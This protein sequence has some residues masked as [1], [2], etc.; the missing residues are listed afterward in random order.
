MLRGGGRLT[1]DIVLQ[2]KYHMDRLPADSL[3]M[4]FAKPSWML[5]HQV[6]AAIFFLTAMA[7]CRL[8]SKSYFG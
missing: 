4:G 7:H 1:R 5:M 2:H 8:N 6:S 3:I